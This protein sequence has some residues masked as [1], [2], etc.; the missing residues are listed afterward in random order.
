MLCSL[1]IKM[2]DNNTHVDL[3]NAAWALKRKFRF[4]KWPTILAVMEI[5]PPDLS[6]SIITFNK[7]KKLNKEIKNCKIGLL[8]K[9]NRRTTMPTK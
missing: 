1:L 4:L 6:R 3:K 9:R 2:I 8:H 5:E 7:K